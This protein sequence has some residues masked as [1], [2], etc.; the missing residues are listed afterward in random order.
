SLPE[1]YQDAAQSILL[2]GPFGINA[3]RPESLCFE[4]IVQRDYPVIFGVLFF[5]TLFSL[6]LRL[7]CDVLYQW[8]DP[9]IH[10]DA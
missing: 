3:L 1:A 2:F 7:I 10:F 4:A 5:F 8:I 9:R 6:L